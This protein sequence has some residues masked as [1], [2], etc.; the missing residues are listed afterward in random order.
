MPAQVGRQKI[1]GLIDIK[2]P[3]ETAMG[4]ARGGAP[5]KPTVEENKTIGGGLMAGA[6]GAAGGAM[7]GTALGGPGIGTAIGGVVGLAAYYLG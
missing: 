4:L 6:G 3:I 7:I 2:N 5:I 1:G